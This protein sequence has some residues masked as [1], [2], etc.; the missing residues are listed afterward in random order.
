MNILNILFELAETISYI[1]YN[2]ISLI[3]DYLCKMQTKLAEYTVVSFDMYNEY[4]NL[5]IHKHVEKANLKSD[6]L[7]LFLDNS[8]KD[9]FMLSSSYV[10]EYFNG[11][12]K[13]APRVT[14]KSPYQDEFIVDLYRDVGEK[15]TFERFSII[16]NTAFKHI[17]DTGVYYICN[18]IP[19]YVRND[20]YVNKR[21]DVNAVKNTIVESFSLKEFFFG[22]TE[23]DIS[24][25]NCWDIDN[26]TNRPSAESCYKSTIVIPMTIINSNV[27]KNF[28]K[29]VGGNS[30]FDK[31]IFGFLCLD[32]RHKE[33]FNDNIDIRFGYIVSDMVS[34]FLI[35]RMMYCSEFILNKDK[36]DTKGK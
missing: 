36:A 21:I 15:G 1:R 19:L 24:W 4:Q 9:V 33:Y 14:F 29:C 12:S 3:N 22:K 17:K 25:E 16:E 10:K 5:L 34:L 35:I 28:I 32:H 27:S 31:T 26:K 20:L 23:R 30:S 2:N 18:N 11:R 7:D 8:I 6:E 13:Y